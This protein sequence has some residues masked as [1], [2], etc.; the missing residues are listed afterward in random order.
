MA[1]PYLVAVGD[2]AGVEVTVG[3]TVAGGIGVPVSDG[4]RVG[5]GVEVKVGTGVGVGVDRLFSR[6]TVIVAA[7]N[8]A[9]SNRTTS[10]VIT[11]LA[12]SKPRRGSV[13]GTS[14]LFRTVTLLV[15]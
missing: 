1:V 4:V 7:K 6:A 15:D 13:L 10:E 11:P 14:F 12:M 2:A 5:V 3:V 8:I 9:T